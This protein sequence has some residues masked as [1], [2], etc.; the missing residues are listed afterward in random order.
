MTTSP[1][2]S[3]IRLGDGHHLPAMGLGAFGMT[4][5]DGVATLVGAP[6]TG[7]R[8]VTALTALGR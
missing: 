7:Y 8:L 3:P 5:E 6:R 2:L 4:V 1:D